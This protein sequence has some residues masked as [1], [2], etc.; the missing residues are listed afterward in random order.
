MLTIKNLT[1]TRLDGQLHRVILSGLNLHIEQGESIAIM[2]DSGSGKSTLLNII[3][4]MENFDSGEILHYP[5]H[6]KDPKAPLDPKNP[7]VIATHTFNSH[8]LTHWRKEHL[9]IVFQQFNLI[10]CLSIIDNIKFPARLNNNLD[11]TW[12]ENIS[13]KLNIRE[14]WSKPV[15]KISGGEQQ[16][17]AVARAVAHKPSLVLADEPTGNLDNQNALQVADLL[18]GICRLRDTP[19]I[20]VTH[21]HRIAQKTDKC[22]QLIKGQLHQVSSLADASVADTSDVTG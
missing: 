4:G 8:Q 2:G 14:L 17:V 19:L 5:A 7:K 3:C 22:L 16:R 15:Q 18:T 11:E 6:S 13:E 10:E 21:S 9:G 20:L 1:K 12:I